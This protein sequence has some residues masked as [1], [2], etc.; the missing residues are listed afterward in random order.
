MEWRVRMRR[1]LLATAAV[2][3]LVAA[4][5]IPVAVFAAPGASIPRATAPGADGRIPWELS[6]AVWN[7]CPMNFQNPEGLAFGVGT[8]DLGQWYVVLYDDQ[9]RE[10][11]EEELGATY[12]ELVGP[13]RIFREC[14][15]KFPTEPYRVPRTLSPA[16]REMYWVY[17]LT[18]LAPCLRGHD[19]AVELPSRDVFA[20]YDYV[21][22]YM[23]QSRIWGSSDSL[24]EQLTIWNECPMLPSY[25]DPAPTDGV[26][27]EPQQAD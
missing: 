26:S 15:N 18:E 8:D 24:D 20:G 9:G 21:E 19:R 13:V 1:R 2:V 5:V 16:Q 14:L 11:P 7:E 23:T 17:V 6:G 25:L 12:P 10:T 27:P 22:W 4:A 3:V